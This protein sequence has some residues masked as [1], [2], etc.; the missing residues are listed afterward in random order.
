[1][2]GNRAGGPGPEGRGGGRADTAADLLSHRRARRERDRRGQIQAL[3]VGKGCGD[4]QAGDVGAGSQGG[5]FR[6]TSGK[7]IPGT[8]CPSLGFSLPATFPL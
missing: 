5:Q 8:L 1:M 7:D 2:W 3:V 4:R 6:V